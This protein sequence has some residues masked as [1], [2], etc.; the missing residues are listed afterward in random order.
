MLRKS[1][2]CL[3]A[4]ILGAA[5]SS[6]A[7]AEREPVLKQIDV[8]HT[9]Y[10]REMYTPQLTSG[11]SSLAW[12]RDGKA[13]YYS[14]QGRIWRQSVSSSRAEQVTT[15]G[16]YDYQPDISPDGRFLVFT[17]YLD[18]AMEL[19]IRDLKSGK[20]TPLTK[21]GA[22]NMDARWSPDGSKIA[23]VTTAESGKFHI[24]I[25]S[26]E[27]GG[28]ITKRW[29]PERVSETKRYYYSAT[30]HEISP[31]WTP[32]GESLLFV[33]NPEII[34]GSGA[35]YRQP[36]DLSSPAILVQNEETAWRMHP[37]V[38][39]DGKRVAYA[40]FFGRQWHQLWMTAAEGGGYPI[41]YSYGDYDVTAQRWS[42]DGKKIAYIS[43]ETGDGV[44]WI[45]EVVGGARAPLKIE[46]RKF[47]GPMGELRFDV[48][49]A[50]GAIVPARIAIRASDG[51]D[52]APNDALIR[53][54]D[55]FNRAHGAFETRYFHTGGEGVV[56]LPPGKATVT[57]WHGMKTAPQ[58]LVVDIVKGKA[59]SLSV[60]LKTDDPN[61]VFSDW[62]SADVHVHMNYG[63]AY[64][65]H[66]DGLAFQAD[67][68]GLDLAFNLIVN[69]EQ[70]I[71][72]IA[73]FTPIPERPEGASAVIAEAQEFH[74]SVWGHTGLIGL[75][76]HYL[77]ADYV[78]YPKTAAHSLY[79]D[80]ATV[81][82]LAHKQSALLGYV[83]PYDPPAP[84]PFAEKFFTHTL[85]VDVALGKVDYLEVVG[86]S[87]HRVTSEVWSRLLNCGFRVAAAG[88]TDAMTNYASM[89][90]PIGLNRTYVKLEN[91]PKDPT[92]FTRA[93]LD[94][95][96][97]G[98]SFATNGPLVSLE[99]EGQG[100]GG[101]L[102]LK[103]GAHKLAFK[104]AMASIAPVDALDLIVNGKVA[105]KI[106][107][108]EGGVGALYSGE[109]EISESGWVSLRA[110][111]AEDSDLVLDG[112]PFA[113]TTPVYVTVGG[114][115][116]RSREDADYF[117]A[118]IGRLEEFAKTS[119]AYNTEEERS[120]VLQH[121]RKAKAEFERRR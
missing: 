114:K 118:W 68:E 26:K 37:D 79:P 15:G 45:Q 5:L 95:L 29:R 34:Y 117:I 86:F 49:D 1:F 77:L 28:W 92:A 18:D 59:A 25:A 67:A 53:A 30:D 57:I 94:G 46:E 10:W 106:P 33:S 72:D 14:M 75:E 22:A 43:N 17:R 60:S 4:T 56:A 51:R 116:A 12:S 108:E 112:Y 32:D 44:I 81:A 11:P 31:A 80:N 88:G 42:P 65:V 83:H 90:G 119:D 3:A 71:P 69:K 82:D 84:N 100:V 36:L 40:S 61:G 97:A 52:Y 113:M 105:Q 115:P 64:R 110:S 87:D 6:P 39:P 41:A 58:K 101:E 73:E 55:N 120:I 93:W 78:G 54:D 20:E 96:K 21:G 62:K 27:G 38:S 66:K 2:L 35:L 89:R 91:A 13:L 24:A 63:G 104:V 19:I 98:H 85:P 102:K 7:F 50:S 76:D 99:V 107:L 48:K 111:N 70:R 16:G 8:P 121:I 103:K 47:A 109:V 9:Y 74:T 23:Y